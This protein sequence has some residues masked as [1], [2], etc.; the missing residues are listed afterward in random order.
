MRGVNSGMATAECEALVL[1][2]LMLAILTGVAIVARP[3]TPIDETRYVSVAW[4]MWLRG[5]FLVPF[6]NGAAYSHKPPL[7]MWLFQLGWAVFGVNEWWPRLV[8][9]LVSAGNL[10]LTLGLARRLWPDR[11]GLAGTAVL[12]LGS[13]LLWTVFSTS[14]MFDIL[15]AFFTLIGMTGIAMASEGRR[16]GF[17]LVALAVGLGTLAKGPVILLHVLPVALL[18]P[19]WNPGLRWVRWYGGF[20]VAVLG[21][22]AI[23]LAWAIPAGMAGGEEYRRAIFWGQTANRMVESFAHR[24]PVWWYVPLLPVLLFP[25]MLWP[26]LWRGIKTRLREGVGRGCRFCLAWMI[27]VFVAFSFISGKQPHYLVPVFPAF[28]LFAARALDDERRL[29]GLWLPTWLVVLMATGASA[30]AVLRPELVLR[31]VG[32]SL[33]LWPIAV[34]A[35]TAAAIYAVGRRSARPVAWLALLG[36]AVSGFVQLGVSPSLYPAHDMRPMANAIRQVQ[37]S[38]RLVAH[39]GTYHAQYQFAGRLRAPLQELDEVADLKNWLAGHADAA[40]VI[41]SKQAEALRE[42]KP[43]AMQRYRDRYVALVDAASALSFRSG[44]VTMESEKE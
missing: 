22:A 41:Y 9:P 44:A 39:L 5:D 26:G 23:A 16:S 36:V 3:M 42:M 31:N 14:A 8:S 30:V 24:R 38:G 7:M 15:L 21:G 32:E 33:A 25:W 18:A 29:N 1:A 11:S 40:V 6:K 2:L 28:A 27:P 43:L 20:L 35:V 4:E 10:L 34:L 19:W 12:I 13:S 17:V 37:E